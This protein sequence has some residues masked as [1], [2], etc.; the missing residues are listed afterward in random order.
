MPD[1][2]FGGVIR[3]SYMDSIPWWPEKVKPPAGAPNILYVLLDDTGFAQLGCYGSRIPTPNMD[4]IAESGIRYR[5]FHTCALCSPTRASLLTGCDNHTLGYSYLSSFDLGFPSLCSKIDQKFGLLSETLQ[6]SGYATFCVGKWHLCRENEMGGAGPFDSWPLSKGFDKFY[7]FMNGATSQFYPDLY[8]DNSIIDAP[9]T[10]E[11]GYHLSS[12]L[13]DHAIKYISTEKATYPD[14]PFFCHLAFGAMHAPLH[15]PQ[16]YVDKFSGVFDE[17]YEEYRKYVFKCQKEIGIIPENAELTEIN[18]LVRPWQTLNAEEKKL[19]SHYM[20]LFAAYLNY[21]DEQLGRL[22][23]Y[24]KKI[25]QYDNTMIVLLSDNGAS[26]EGGVDGCFN[27]LHHYL[28]GEWEGKLNNE[29]YKGLGGSDSYPLYPRGWAWAGNTPLKMYKTWVHEGGIRVP[30]IISYPNLIKDAGGIR[31]QYHYVTDLYAT[32]LDV[33]GVK[34]PEMIKGVR[35]EKKP[36][37][38]MK[39]TF[40]DKNAP[41]RRRVQFS[42]MF[43]NRS[44]W[45]D[46]WK[47]VADHTVSPTFDNDKWELYNTDEDFSEMHD[48]A[49]QYPEKL[50]ELIHL[51]WKEAGTYGALPL[52]ESPF[53]HL[54][55]FNLNNAFK[56]APAENVKHYRFYPEMDISAPIP[57]M[58]NKSFVI[59]ARAEYKKGYEGILY[60][61]GFTVGGYTLYIEND[62]LCF[63]YNYLGERNTA[64]VSEAGLPEGEHDFTFSFVNT[65]PG[66]G[67]GYVMVDGKQSGGT[68]QFEDSLFSVKNGFAVGR[69]ATGPINLEHHGKQNHF[70][71]PG[72]ICYIDLD[73]DKPENDADRV[74]ALEKELETE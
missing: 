8:Q 30:C 72:T 54:N 74:L 13:V 3:T 37:I 45:C 14:K 51:W 9:K 26:A 50:H 31:D 28:S 53:K 25:G 29:K 55:G 66:S 48:L 11:E 52:L 60:C 58:T 10:P 68:V 23:D 32:V 16:E 57:R 17:G 12:D 4:A 63:F 69:Y 49:E 71:Y 27:E 34:Q 56:F 73:M 40:D 41:R 22:L 47:A 42:E 20:E 6:Q 36:G 19:F 59:T 46:G 2:K 1:N 15:A 61:C 35:Q 38:S 44:I 18:D 33:C 21:T 62:K 24:L 5:N 7:G 65:C 64:V 43:G 70:A 39:Y 67:Y